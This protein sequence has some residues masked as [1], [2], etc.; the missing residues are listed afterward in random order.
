MIIRAQDLRRKR[1]E[2][3]HG[4]SGEVE[5]REF[6][7]PAGRAGFRLLHETTVA[8]GATIGVHPHP[9]QEEL[10]IIRE[11]RALLQDDGRTVRVGPGDVCYTPS[12]HA[13]GLVNDGE[14]PLKMTV[15]GVNL[16]TD[17]SIPS[18]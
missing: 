17:T 6:R 3:C 1:E 10:Y 7:F 14:V 13:H 5:I 9:G 2:S 8:P 11:G 16:C 15:V 12:G 18:S 4:G